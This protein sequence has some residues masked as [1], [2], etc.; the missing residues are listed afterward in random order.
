MDSNSS[1]DELVNKYKNKEIS[2]RQL[3]YY[4]K[5]Y[6]LEEL[7]NRTSFVETTDPIERIYYL[8]NDLHNIVRCP[9]CGKKCSFTKRIVDG[10]YLTCS[11]KSC[12][13]AQ[14]SKLKRDGII[15]K[16]NSR[17]N[18]KFIDYQKTLKLED[19]NDDLINEVFFPDNRGLKRNYL[20]YIENPIKEY[21]ENRFKDSDSLDESLRRINLK[22]EE[23]PKCPTCGGPVVFIGKPKKM[24]TKHCCDSCSARSRETIEKKEETQMRHWGSRCCYNSEA[25]KE[26]LKKTIGVEYHFQRDDIKNKRKETL[27]EHFGTT[28]IYQLPEI[29]EK[30]RKTCLERY[31]TENAMQCDEIKKKIT[32]SFRKNKSWKGPT[33][34][35]EMTIR[36]FLEE[37]FPDLIWQYYSKEYPFRCDFYIPSLNLYIEYNGSHYHYTHFFNPNDENDIKRKEDLES[38]MTENPHNT[39]WHMYNTWLNTDV[40]KRKHVEENNINMVWIWGPDYNKGLYHILNIINEYIETHDLRNQNQSLAI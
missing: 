15:K 32:E 11:S 23:K 5:T 9:I 20:P 16:T 39:Y 38:K 7:E 26:H 17:L 28:K 40:K 27:I 8:V 14:V 3:I 31:G 34:K 1:L 25:Y 33:S 30:S 21:L 35:Q 19:I 24:F 37:H 6:F 36:D 18:Q 29:R 13:S 4:V 12:L 10:Y 22:I 2:Q